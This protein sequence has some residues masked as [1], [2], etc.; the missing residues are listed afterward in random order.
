MG[1]RAS[2]FGTDKASQY[3]VRPSDID[4]TLTVYE[5]T[6]RLVY[7]R[8]PADHKLRNMCEYFESHSLTEQLVPLDEREFK[9]MGMEKSLKTSFERS[10]GYLTQNYTIIFRDSEKDEFGNMEACEPTLSFHFKNVFDV[11]RAILPSIF[12]RFQFMLSNVAVMHHF[13]QKRAAKGNDSPISTLN[14]S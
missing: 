8:F 14:A 5:N 2:I 4:P 10:R 11:F 6:I 1:R 7:A 12:Q 13:M 9:M 3:W